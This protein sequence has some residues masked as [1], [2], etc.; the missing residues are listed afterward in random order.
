MQNFFMVNALI[1]AGADVN[2]IVRVENKVYNMIYKEELSGMN[3]IT[4]A[5]IRGNVAI[6]ERLIDEGAN[7]NLRIKAIGGK[8]AFKLAQ[9]SHNPKV[10][11][12]VFFQREK[13]SAFKVMMG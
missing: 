10:R 5:V 4:I 2:K 13:A 6:I 1:K 8:T 12:A 9:E 3:P 7:P 11:A